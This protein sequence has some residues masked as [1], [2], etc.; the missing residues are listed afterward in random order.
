MCVCVYGT[1]SQCPQRWTVIFLHP[2]LVILQQQ[3][4]SR[5][6]SVELIDP[7]T[8]DHFPIPAWTHTH[9]CRH[10][11][12]SLKLSSLSVSGIKEC[13]EEEAAPWRRSHLGWG[14]RA[15]SQ[16]A[17]WW[18][19]C[20]GDHTRHS[21]VLWSS[22]CPPHSQTRRHPGNQRRTV[23]ITGRWDCYSKTQLKSNQLITLATN[24]WYV[25]MFLNI[26][27]SLKGNFVWTCYRNS[28]AVMLNTQQRL[29]P[30]ITHN[31]NQ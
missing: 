13:Q 12:L 17:Q 4:Q 25:R 18:R 2:V 23:E 14:T 27:H 24:N 3:T 15:C 31:N 8:L 10:A 1:W 29:K 9:R 5:W 28:Q 26:Y 19:R 6:S 7:E 21:C 20:T 11:H 22:Q 16:R 30:W